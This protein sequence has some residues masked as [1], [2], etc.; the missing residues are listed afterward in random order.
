MKPT[1][2]DQEGDAILKNAQAALK[3]SKRLI[4]F[5]EKTM[6]DNKLFMAKFK[7]EVATLRKML[8]EFRS[9]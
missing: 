5:A 7:R 3:E 4:A 8:R 6:A 2:R 9:N 1:R